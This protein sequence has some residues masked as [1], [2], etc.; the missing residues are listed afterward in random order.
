[1]KS[2]LTVCEIADLLFAD[3]NAN[4]SRC[5]AYALATHLDEMCEENTEFDRAAIRCDY[6]QYDSLIVFAEEYFGSLA[7]AFDRF[8]LEFTPEETSDLSE[9]VRAFVV[10]NGELLEFDDGVIISSF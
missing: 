10:D 1:M 7:E 5:G 6:A 4:W 9:D 3:D 8:G 2:T